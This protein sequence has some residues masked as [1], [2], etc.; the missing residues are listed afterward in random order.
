V[1][2]LVTALL[3]GAYLVAVFW[4][5]LL[6]MR[7][8]KTLAGF[9]VGNKDMGPVLV[10]VVMASSIASTAT[11]VINPGFVYTHGLSAFLH[12]AVAAQAGMAFGLVAVTKGFRRVGDTHRCLTIPDWIR[13]RY[14]SKPLALFFALINLLS[15]T[16]VVLIMVGC[17]LLVVGLTG[18]PYALALV[19]VLVVV[20]SY[21]LMGGTYAHAY[22][23]AVQAAMMA[24]VAVVL[25]G[26]G[27]HLLD[28]GFFDALRG[29]SPAWAA[30]VNP[31]SA[32]YGSTFSVFVSAFV[33]TF[34]LMMQPHILTKVLYLRSE[35]DVTRFLVT[36]IALGAVFSLC[37]FVGF[38]AR[39]GGI[40]LPVEAQDRVVTTY[41]AQ[42]FGDALGGQ[43][44]SATVLVAL[45]AAGMSTLDGILVALSAMV[46]NDLYLPLAGRGATDRSLLVSRIVLVVVGLVAFLLA[47]DPPTFV[48]LFAQKGVYGLAAASFV[49]IV[50]GV[51][52]RA[53][54]SARIMSLAAGTGLAVHLYLDLAHGVANPAV[55]ACYAILASVMIALL[56]MAW[57]RT[58]R[59]AT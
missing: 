51:L 55:S 59:S 24:V 53:T 37:L 13:A 15:I 6:G 54:I 36:A 33:V 56:S 42:A 31:E 4:L 47:L 57:V 48:G 27:L 46:T 32:L 19:A 49:P 28:G 20:F 23:N 11:F 43:L 9:A 3:L 22:T 26:S 16:F 50:F 18:L 35:R 45:L 30:P 29:V 58:R 14:G 1:I 52:V 44:V 21:V 38:Y 41:V 7:K 5:S 40:E 39:L 17:A 10:G 12:Y 2:A 25:F 34:A 8:T